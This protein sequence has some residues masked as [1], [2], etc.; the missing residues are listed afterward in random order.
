MRVDEAWQ[1][2]GIPEIDGFGARRYVG[3]SHSGGLDFPARDHDDAG[4]DQ[5]IRLAVEQPRG[6]QH[7][8]VVLSRADCSDGKD[9]KE[10]THAG[11]YSGN[12]G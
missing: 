11:K 8:R 7:D 4:R 3:R 9:Q 1:Q 5:A 10:P 2:R 6:A 12:L